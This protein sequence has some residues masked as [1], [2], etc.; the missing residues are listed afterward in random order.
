MG[1]NLFKKPLIF[2]LIS[3]YNQTK[4]YHSWLVHL[5]HLSHAV[6]AV[7]H[8]KINWQNAWLA[9]QRTYHPLFTIILQETKTAIKPVHLAFMVITPHHLFARLVMYPVSNVTQAQIHALHAILQIQPTNT[10]TTIAVLKI[11][12]M[13]SL[14]DLI[15]VKNAIPNAK[16][17]ILVRVTAPPAQ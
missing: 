6:I 10:W 5:Q 4:S 14:C 9:I 3:K 7:S 1:K 12:Q 11:A 8:A 2:E 15:F 16:P 13:E 17:A